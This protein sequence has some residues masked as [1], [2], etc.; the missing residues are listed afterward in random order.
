MFNNSD[1]AARL[2]ALISQ[3]R[4]ETLGCEPD[5]P[6]WRVDLDLRYG[7]FLVETA[8]NRVS[9]FR[10]VDVL[11]VLAIGVLDRTT[12]LASCASQMREVAY[13][14]S[15]AAALF[16]GDVSVADPV[17]C[18]AEMRLFKEASMP[19][20]EADAELRER[21]LL[22]PQC[23]GRDVPIALLATGYDLDVIARG[24]GLER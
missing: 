15:Q 13:L 2:A 24:Y 6:D 21:V 9:R 3:L 19:S 16:G 23:V 1:Y 20:P 17:R 8:K 22:S 5:V 10:D 4:A 11:S 12:Y 7:Q 14:L 18:E